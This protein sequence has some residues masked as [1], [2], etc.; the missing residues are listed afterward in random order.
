MTFHTYQLYNSMAL[1]L[2]LMLEM[3]REVP[4]CSHLCYTP[5]EYTF[6][7]SAPA[8]MHLLVSL[9]FSVGYD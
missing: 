9:S 5:F 2:H 3:K 8:V 4:A 1:F 7:D 6:A